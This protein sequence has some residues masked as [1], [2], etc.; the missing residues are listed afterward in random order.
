MHPSKADDYLLFIEQAVRYYGRFPTVIEYNTFAR[1]NGLPSHSAIVRRTGRRW[2]ELY[3]EVG[4]PRNPRDP[5]HIIEHLRLAAEKYGHAITK[6]QYIEY[7]QATEG[8]PSLRDVCVVYST[9]NNAKEAAG[10]YPNR[11]YGTEAVTPEV[12]LEALKTFAKETGKTKFTENEYEEW[13]TGTQ[14]PSVETIRIRF[15]T[16]SAAL[17]EAGYEPA[18]MF[19]EDSMWRDIFDFLSERINLEEYNRWA[20]QNGRTHFDEYVLRGYKFRETM[21]KAC[22]TY[23][24]R[25]QN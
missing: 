16:F 2:S 4:E 15:K 7:A 14:Y 11:G 12:C 13:R 8:A 21:K 23:F 20:Q 6:R 17:L 9:Y 22:D 3:I 18:V 1:E 24:N 10:L 19:S 5:K 25:K